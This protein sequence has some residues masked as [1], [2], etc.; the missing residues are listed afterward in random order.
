[1]QHH[2]AL[3][4]AE[5]PAFMTQLRRQAGAAARCLELTILTAARTG[6]A[7]GARWPEVDL[8]ARTWTVPAERMKAGKPHVVPLSDRALELAPAA[9]G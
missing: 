5:L 7:I 1:V 2:K 6:E 9:L 8:E 4:Y 3:P